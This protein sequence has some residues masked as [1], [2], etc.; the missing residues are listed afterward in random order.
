[1]FRNVF[2]QL[3]T[4]KLILRLMLEGG[5]H[6]NIRFVVLNKKTNSFKDF[7]DYSA[8]FQEFSFQIKRWMQSSWWCSCWRLR[9]CAQVLHLQSSF[10][11]KVNS[12]ITR[13]FRFQIIL[14]KFGILF[15]CQPYCQPLSEE[16]A[17]FFQSKTLNMDIF[18][19]QNL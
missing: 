9:L 12:H 11:K 6:V 19:E 18:K 5:K 7:Y 3:I 15:D 2:I 4:M 14:A 8:F 1:M 13:D 16:S 17:P 10:T